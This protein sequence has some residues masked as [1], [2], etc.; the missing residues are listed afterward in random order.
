[1]V[2]ARS[3]VDGVAVLTAP[4]STMKSTEPLPPQPPLSTSG[5]LAGR[6]AAALHSP[7]QGEKLRPHQ[8]NHGGLSSWPS[9][10]APGLVKKLDEMLR[11]HYEWVDGLGADAHMH[12]PY[13]ATAMQQHCAAIG[14]LCS[15]LSDSFTQYAPVL[16]GIAG[17]AEQM[18]SVYGLLAS[19]ALAVQENNEVVDREHAREVSALKATIAEQRD[20]MDRLSETAALVERLEAAMVE[21]RNLRLK[22]AEAEQRNQKLTASL[23]EQ[24][25]QHTALHQRCVRANA[26]EDRLKGMVASLEGRL[27]KS[28]VLG[29]A[30]TIERDF[31]REK[32]DGQAEEIGDIKHQNSRLVRQMSD[33]EERLA[34]AQEELGRAE[35][36]ANVKGRRASVGREVYE[37]PSQPAKRAGG[38]APTPRPNWNDFP[39]IIKQ[40]SALINEA[41]RLQYIHGPITFLESHSAVRSRGVAAR[42]GPPIEPFTPEEEGVKSSDGRV[43]LLSKALASSHSFVSDLL[44]TVD[45]LVAYTE[46]LR[47]MYTHL[48]VEPLETYS[49]MLQYQVDSI[50]LEI[51]SAGS[52][53]ANPLSPKAHQRPSI[54]HPVE[55]DRSTTSSSGARAPRKPP[56]GRPHPTVAPSPPPPPFMCGH[57]LFNPRR[58]TS[59]GAIVVPSRLAAPPDPTRALSDRGYARGLCDTLWAPAPTDDAMLVVQKLLLRHNLDVNESEGEAVYDFAIPMV[60]ETRP[61][62]AAPKSPHQ[63]TRAFQHVAEHPALFLPVTV[64]VDI[65]EV[66]YDYIAGQQ[67]LL[68]LSEGDPTAVPLDASESSLVRLMDPAS[69]P[70]VRSFLEEFVEAVRFAVLP[71]LTSIGTLFEGQDRYLMSMERLTGTERGAD[72]Q[73]KTRISKK[74]SAGVEP[75]WASLG[76]LRQAP[77]SLEGP[78]QPRGRAVSLDSVV[79]SILFHSNR[80]YQRLPAARLFLLHIH[81]CIPKAAFT[82]LRR[83]L[84]VV[85]RRV[86]EA[87]PNGLVSLSVKVGDL[88]TVPE[89]VAAVGTDV[90]F[91]GGSWQPLLQESFIGDASTFVLLVEGSHPFHYLLPAMSEYSLRGEEGRTRLPTDTTVPSSGLFSSD[92]SVG[93]V[94]FQL[95]AGSVRTVQSQQFDLLRVVLDGALRVGAADKQLLSTRSALSSP[96]SPF[97][98]MVVHAFITHLLWGVYSV[99]GALREVYAMAGGA[100]GTGL[101]SLLKPAETYPEDATLSLM[102]VQQALE[103]ADPAAR[104]E[105]LRKLL[106]DCANLHPTDLIPRHK[107]SAR[108]LAQRLLEVPYLRATP[109]PPPTKP[110]TG[111][112]TLDLFTGAVPATTQVATTLPG[113]LKGFRSRPGAADIGRDALRRRGMRDVA[114]E[115]LIRFTSEPFVPM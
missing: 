18:L 29:E 5:R 114:D 79:Y 35:R 49:G 88:P 55:L 74:E 83:S 67:V 90:P 8:T 102:S 93:D 4:P 52:S 100:V 17:I 31:L 43:A 3:F 57:L 39:S 108:G 105:V 26:A 109:L 36:R 91:L 63:D 25:E 60:K 64:L 45:A 97:A 30:L 82:L 7:L 33:F 53:P 89:V 15:S 92:P 81:G 47:T 59:F 110:H 20:E 80:V 32:V 113:L 77:T 58:G 94:P 112:D 104:P 75:P 71:K 106:G 11:R 115:A 98:Q 101:Q 9:S 69:L 54:A 1:M 107:F 14:H 42:S 51:Q 68:G 44:H 62:K 61:P 38:R 70:P 28:T 78:S 48:G 16:S 22:L 84:A 21:E 99:Q 6:Y 86:Q 96:C 73:P 87:A 76:Y 12:Q 19:S 23:S 40:H 13:H 111:A 2:V 50:R 34:A 65:Y 66:V 37:P 103:K 95:A 85:R 24:H 72:A 56:S 10:A 46:S 27:E 41:T